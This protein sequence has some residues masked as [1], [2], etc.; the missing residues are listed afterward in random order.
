FRA[1]EKDSAAVS[2]RLS[3]TAPTAVAIP[4]PV[5]SEIAFGIERLLRSTR[6]AALQERFDFIA[7]ELPRPSERCA[8]CRVG[9]V[10]PQRGVRKAVPIHAHLRIGRR[11]T[12]NRTTGKP[13]SRRLE[14]AR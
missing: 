5:I 14:R 13:P 9:V 6:R 7:P 1:H 4:R 11:D 3:A 8:K 2:E 10:G 12:I